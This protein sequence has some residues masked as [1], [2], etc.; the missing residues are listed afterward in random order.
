MQ[1]VETR[2]HADKAHETFPFYR[3]ELPLQEFLPQADGTKRLELAELG[4]DAG[5]KDCRSVA[6]VGVKAGIGGLKFLHVDSCRI[7]TRR[8]DEMIA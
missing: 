3:M 6:N 1:R 2:H 5:D 4:K 8:V 7:S